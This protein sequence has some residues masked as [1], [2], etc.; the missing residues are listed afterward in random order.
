MSETQHRRVPLRIVTVLWDNLS[1]TENRYS[2]H[3]LLLNTFR[4]QNLRNHEVFLYDIFWFCETKNRRKNLILPLPPFIHK[5]FFKR[6]V[7]EIQHRNVALRI[8][9]ALWDKTTSTEIVIA[10]TSLKLNTFRHQNFFESMNGS[11]TKSFGTVRQKIFDGKFWYPPRLSHKPFHQRNN[12]ETQHRR[13][14]LRNVT[15]LWDKTISTENHESQPLS[16][17]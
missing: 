6:N 3:S 10:A 11:S 17:T 4:Y 13:V 1:W 14:L 5:F 7:S 12:S 8:V 16:Y 9:T 2:R 15:V